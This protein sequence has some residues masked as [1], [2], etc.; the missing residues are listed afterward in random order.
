MVWRSFGQR[1]QIRHPHRPQRLGAQVHH[2][3]TYLAFPMV[4][5]KQNGRPPREMTGRR[6][7]RGVFQRRP[8]PQRRCRRRWR[9][10]NTTL[11]VRA[12]ASG[13]GIPARPRPSPQ[14]RSPIYRPAGSFD[15]EEPALRDGGSDSSGPRTTG[16]GRGQRSAHE[17][18][19]TRPTASVISTTRV[20]ELQAL[21]E[22]AALVDG[23]R[24]WPP[25]PRARG[26]PSGS[27]R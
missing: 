14:H 26:P 5:Q 2:G 24:S 9:V 8:N 25:A 23:A 16:R 7:Q 11:M 1:A 22:L 3:S 21:D 12:A 19:H 10:I 17:L 13:G 27:S 6:S 20:R 4:Q 15:N 18:E